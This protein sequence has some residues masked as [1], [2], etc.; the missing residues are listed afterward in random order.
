MQI[1][2][3]L[4]L[5]GVLELQ[6]KDSSLKVSYR[7]EVELTD[8]TQNKFV[9]GYKYYLLQRHPRH[10]AALRSTYKF[11]VHNCHM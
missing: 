11:L 9:F 1:P 5:C 6:N 10:Q 3:T 4:A 2:L 8:L 7:N